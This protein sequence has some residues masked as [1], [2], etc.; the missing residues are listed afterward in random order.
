MT[1]FT[2]GTF[3]WSALGGTFIE[4]TV[5]T[6]QDEKAPK[7]TAEVSFSTSPEGSAFIYVAGT[8]TYTTSAKYTAINTAITFT[9]STTGT[10]PV[11]YE[12]YFGDGEKA[13]G[14]PVI[15]TYIVQNPNCQAVLKVTD[16]LGKSYYT[17]RQMYLT[18]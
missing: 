1:T 16:A 10:T 3:S 7:P 2:K 6:I 4:P 12:W 11:E 17:R 5:S 15:H 14:N 13:W 9:A 8:S 18:S